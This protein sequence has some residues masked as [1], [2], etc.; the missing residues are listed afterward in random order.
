M[1]G[2]RSYLAE[3]AFWVQTF[4]RAVKTFCQTAIGLLVGEE[5]GIIGTDWSVL[6]SVAGAAALVSV[7]TSLGSGTGP[8]PNAVAYAKRY[9][10]EGQHERTEGPDT[11]AIDLGPDT[12]AVE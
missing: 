3:G 10:Y 5:L 12:P 11:P 6:S 4:E 1:P 9:T 2:M 8:V 7:L